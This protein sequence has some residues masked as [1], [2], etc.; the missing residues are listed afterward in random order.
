VT[1][2]QA[3]A[4][5]GAAGV[6][7]NGTDPLLAAAPLGER[8]KTIVFNIAAVTPAQRKLNDY[9][10]GNAVLADTESKQMVDT[11]KGVF[12]VSRLA[13]VYDDNAFGDMFRNFLTAAAK[14][15]GLNVT[16]SVRPPAQRSSSCVPCSTRDR[17]KSSLAVNG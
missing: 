7:V 11:M 14:A 1:G 4:A 13:I 8:M 15:S 9:V 17:M 5:E 16:H 12:G 2:F 3:L 6:L 10:F